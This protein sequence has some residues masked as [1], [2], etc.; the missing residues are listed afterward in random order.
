MAEEWQELTEAEG[1]AKTGIV[2]EFGVGIEREVGAV[3]GEVAV[4]EEAELLIAGA[5]PGVGRGPEEAM[6]DDE[7]VGPG[8]G[9]VSECGAGGVDGG[10]DTR[11]VSVIL[12]LQ[13]VGGAVPVLESGDAEESIAVAGE[14]GKGG[15]LHG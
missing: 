10:G 15:G 13:A 14:G 9:G 4:E 11:H 7:E 3:D 2:A 8:G 5:D 12:D 1:A 6:V